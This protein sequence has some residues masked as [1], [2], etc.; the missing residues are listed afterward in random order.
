MKLKE[1]IQSFR[2]LCPSPY[3][4]D[5]LVAWIGELDGMAIR[6]VYEVREGNPVPEDWKYYTAADMEAEL[7]IPAPFESVYMHWL[8]S[9]TDYWQDESNYSNSSKAFNNGYMSFGDWWRRTHAPVHKRQWK[10]FGGG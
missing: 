1:A 5:Q 2:E 3:S 7:L 10:L 8:K 6:D 4:T 9:M